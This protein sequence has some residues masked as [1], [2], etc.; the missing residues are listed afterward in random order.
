MTTLDGVERSFDAET[1]LVCDR[2]GP[3]RDRR[4]HGRPGLRGLRDDHPGA[5]RGRD[6]ERGQHPAHLAQARP[7]LRR[8]EPRSRSSFTPSSRCARQR[9]A[10]QL[11]V[12]LCGARL[13]PGTIDVAAEIPAPHRIAPAR[14]RAPSAARRRDPDRRASV[15]YLRAARVRGRAGDGDDLEADGPVPPPLRRHPRG[16]PGRG[17]RAASTATPSTCRATLPASA[18]PG[19]RADPRAA[20]APPRRGRAPR[21]RLRRGRHPEPRRPGLA[22]R[23]RLAGRR[24][25]RAS[26]S[27]SPTRS[28][29][30]TRCCARRC[31]AACSTPPAT[32]SPAA[33]SASRCSSPGRAYLRERRPAGGGH[34]RRQLPGRAPGARVRAASARRAAVGELAR[35]RAAAGAATARA[36]TST[37]SRACSRRSRAQLGVRGRGRAGERA[38]PASRAAPAR[39]RASAARRSAGSAS[40]TRSSAAPGTSTR[41]PAFELDLAPLVGGLAGRRRAVR[42]RDHLPGGPPGHRGRRRRGRRRRRGCARRSREAGGE[43]LRVGRDLR[44]LPRRAGRRG[45]QEPRAAARV[46]RPRPHAHRRRGRRACASGSR[47]RSAEIGGSLRE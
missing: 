15:E 30:S 12:E 31:S 42:G 3:D 8:L 34:A 43:L 10:S 22:E 38:V 33:P 2:D 21:P 7:A 20:P 9:V 46:P 27:R 13:V 39:D 45:P 29:A 47:R 19:R 11:M 18:E 16:R 28:R 37:R 36:P 41:P 25:A 26:R 17:G 35:C 5:A 6:L 40:S 32:T 23:L 1:V 4:D 14:R 24:S 44:P